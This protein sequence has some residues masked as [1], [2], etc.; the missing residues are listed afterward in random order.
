MARPR[1]F[2]EEEVVQRAMDVFWLHG[3]EAA[4]LT[5]IL[6]ATGLAKGS[7]YKAFGDKK[8]LFMLALDAYLDNAN[9]RLVDVAESS[10]SGRKALDEIFA[11]V[12][13]MSTCRGVRRGACP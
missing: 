3:Y 1:E 7:L 9:N 4:S 6:D 13:R 5:D 2:D 10:A 11:G 12:V 8:Q